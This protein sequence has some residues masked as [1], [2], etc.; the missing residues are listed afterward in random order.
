MAERV[1]VVPYDS[2]WIETFCRESNRLKHA[3]HDLVYRVHHVG[4]TA[5]PGMAAKPVI[6]I[7]I[8]ATEFPPSDTAIAALAG[9]GYQHRGSGSVPG[10]HWFSKGEP[11]QFHL[12]WCPVGGEVVAAQLRFREKAIANPELAQAYAACKQSLAGRYDIDS[13]EYVRA[14]EAALLAVLNGPLG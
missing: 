12:H 6:D 10:R 4:S 8:E 14:K 2:R 1:T 5:I 11:R 13:I 7:C 9:I 3:L